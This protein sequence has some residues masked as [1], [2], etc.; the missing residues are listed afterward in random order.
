MKRKNEPEIVAYGY[1]VA[2]NEGRVQLHTLRGNASESWAALVGHKT[3]R[4]E[5]SRYK[6]MG[7]LTVSVFVRN[8]YKSSVSQ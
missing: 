1:V 3:T 7:F 8:F 4:S 5:R 6:K 2:D